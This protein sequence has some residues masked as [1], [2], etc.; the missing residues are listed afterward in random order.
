MTELG[1]VEA[2]NPSPAPWI[3]AD[4]FADRLARI[5]RV[6]GWNFM[7]AG[8]ATGL[9]G[10]SWRLWEQHN[11]QPYNLLEVATKI[12]DACGVSL[13][14]LLTGTEDSERDTVRYRA[15]YPRSWWLESS[16]APVAIPTFSPAA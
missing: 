4:T 1:A 2:G 13:I 7:E 5:R 9:S 6:K 10:K 14:W 15:T 16:G 8:R 12:S 11:R 3:P